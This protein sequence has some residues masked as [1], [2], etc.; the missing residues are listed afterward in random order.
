MVV[1][2]MKNLHYIFCKVD[3]NGNKIFPLLEL[4]GFFRFQ[5]RLLTM[6]TFFEIAVYM[7]SYV[8]TC[9]NTQ[10]AKH[11]ENANFLNFAGLI[12]SV[13]RS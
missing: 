10:I 13:F 6:T 1:A 4:H 5:Y 8:K 11:D 3:A 7:Y 2:Q 9:C 12:W